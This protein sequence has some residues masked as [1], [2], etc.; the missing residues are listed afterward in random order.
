[1]KVYL[2]GKITGT[3]LE[4]TR[5][6]F[7]NKEIELIK[8]EHEVVNPFDLEPD[9]AEWSD[10]MKTDIRAMLNCDAVFFFRDFISS[11]GAMVEFNLAVTLN[12]IVYFEGI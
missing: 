3:D 5:E 8:K 1:M 11:R 9:G 7:K 6:K 10:Y 4:V 12:I 2:S